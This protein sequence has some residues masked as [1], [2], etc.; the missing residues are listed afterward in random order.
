MTPQEQQL[1]QGLTDRINQTVLQDKDPEAEQYLTQSLS[2]NPDAVYILAQTVLV[3]QYA[4]DQAK[5]QLDDA[6]QR[7]AQQQAPPAPV[8]HTSFLGN[9]LG[10]EE[11]ARTP[12]PPPP[13]PQQYGQPQYAP[14]PNYAP[15]TSR[16][17]TAPIRPARL[18]P[19][20]LWRASIW[21]AHGRRLRFPRL[22][23]AHRRR[24]RRGRHCL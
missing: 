17:R 12:P 4:L 18:W 10:D 24:R 21:R 22:R 20:H 8:R 6:K 19:T 1:L 13:L 3:Q 11:P 14:V 7:L 9:L 16:L 5:K 15:P 2:R 23:A